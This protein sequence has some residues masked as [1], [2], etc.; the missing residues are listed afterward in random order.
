MHAH[1]QIPKRICTYWQIFGW[2]I[3]LATTTQY[4]NV[5]Q[6]SGICTAILYY[7]KCFHDIKFECD[8]LRIVWPCITISTISS[9][10]YRWEGRGGGGGGGGLYRSNWPNAVKKSK[11][12]LLMLPNLKIQF[13]S[14][15]ENVYFTNFA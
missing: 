7:F 13:Q 8:I 12:L 3:S 6:V 5:Y 9:V 4:Y 1:K 15:F 11:N 10:D 14:K 2:Y